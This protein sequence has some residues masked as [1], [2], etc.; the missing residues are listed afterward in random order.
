VP[1]G[2]EQARAFR[3]GYARGFHRA[4]LTGL[5]PA[6]PLP[7]PAAEALPRLWRLD[8]YEVRHFVA[9][10]AVTCGAFAPDESVVFTAGADGAVR[11]WPVPAPAARQP[12]EARITYVGSQ[13]ERGTDTV[14]VRAELENPAGAELRLR[15]GLFANLRVYP[16]ADAA[17]R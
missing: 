13:L 3:G 14:R 8:G 1:A 9:P 17:G 10:A 11:V 2:P 5:L 4:S 7:G 16:E 15:P 6:G 12:L